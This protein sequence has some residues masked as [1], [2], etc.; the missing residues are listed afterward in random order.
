MQEGEGEREGRRDAEGGGCR[1]MELGLTDRQARRQTDMQ[2][3]KERERALKTDTFTD[4]RWAHTRKQ[5]V[6]NNNK[7]TKKKPTVH[8]RLVLS[9]NRT[10]V[11][12]TL[13]TVRAAEL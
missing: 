6:K 1:V 13:A 2:E 7:Q 12:Y 4:M 3:G 8:V 5:T 10:W 11:K 9:R